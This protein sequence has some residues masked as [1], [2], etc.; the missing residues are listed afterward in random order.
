MS[1]VPVVR[2]AE[3]GRAAIGRLCQHMRKVTKTDQLCD[4]VCSEWLLCASDYSVLDRTTAK[5]CN[6]ICAYWLHVSNI[7][8]TVG[9]KK[10]QHL[11]F[12]AK[13]ALTL[14]HSS[15]SPE[16]GFSVNDALVMKETGSLS[17]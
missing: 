15:A 17:E 2:K 6:D 10:Y 16:R 12:V 11:S 14:S 1:V 8:D 9:E 13:A 7:V 4:T 5:F 3:T